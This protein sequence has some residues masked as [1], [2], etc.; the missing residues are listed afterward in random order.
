MLAG[1]SIFGRQGEMCAGRVRVAA[2]GGRKGVPI[3]VGGAVISLCCCY[4]LRLSP[5]K[6]Q[7]L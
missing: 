3:D 2:Q 1:V 4:R 6:P 7:L 5:T